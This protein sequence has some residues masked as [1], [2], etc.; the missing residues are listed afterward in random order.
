MVVAANPHQ[1]NH[2][3]YDKKTIRNVSM[4]KVNKCD[5]SL[6][7]AAIRNF[8]VG[9]TDILSNNSCRIN[10]IDRS[11]KTA[12]HHAA[13]VG[14][15][16]IVKKLIDSGSNLYA[17]TKISKSNIFH[18]AALSGKKY[19]LVYLSEYIKET[20]G[21]N[22][23]IRLATSLNNNGKLPAHCA[24]Q[25]G[26][27]EAFMYLIQLDPS[28]I[29]TTTNDG[30]TY[31]HLA[32]E[33]GHF[34]LVQHLYDSKLNFI[35][36]KEPVTTDHYNIF[37]YAFHSGNVQ[38]AKYIVEKYK[39]NKPSYEI[40]IKNQ[41]SKR[42]TPVHAAALSSNI[43][44][45]E[46]V[47]G[48]QNL[49]LNC[50]NM[51]EHRTPLCYAAISGSIQMVEFLL[52]KG[53]ELNAP[54]TVPLLHCAAQ[55]GNIEIIKL[56]LSEKYNLKNQL[57]MTVCVGNYP[58]NIFHAAVFSGTDEMIKYLCESHFSNDEI[59]RLLIC[60]GYPSP[61]EI[62][63]AR[64]NLIAV[65][66]FVNNHYYPSSIISSLNAAAKNRYLDIVEFLLDKFYPIG[67]IYD[68]NELISSPLLNL[69]ATWCEKIDFFKLLIEKRNFD[70]HKPIETKTPFMNALSSGNFPIVEMYINFYPPEDSTF[71]L[72]EVARSGNVKLAKYLIQHIPK[73]LDYLKTFTSTQS[74][75][76]QPI[77][78]AVISKKIKLIRYFVETLGA[79]VNA[80]NEFRLTPLH[81]ASF[82]SFGIC[83]KDQQQII[84]YLIKSGAYI[85]LNAKAQFFPGIHGNGLTPIDVASNAQIKKI[86]EK[87]SPII[88]AERLLIKPGEVSIKYVTLF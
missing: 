14:N 48:I 55:G 61:I 21:E 27:I 23:F 49:Q 57:S 58:T 50:I 78:L 82:T 51:T 73:V 18:C 70:P 43:E 80:F 15:I 36:G 52:K 47:L 79:N 4:F 30:R 16:D 76:L 59:K 35:D 63:C 86:L 42:L 84:E 71:L 56:L 31:H 32:A 53:A 1:N 83:T 29:K 28:Q 64:G 24:A 45:A 8:L 7:T 22:K 72:H 77:H 67:S 37:F 10:E 17:K 40:T 87:Y 54:C 12:L 11:G 69:L 9:V 81:F 39:D 20:K 34:E 5:I 65:E 66:Y 3:K 85:S 38:L 74:G 6:H 13:S 41:S 75:N 68:E 19:L 46:Y 62:A 44:L 26:N 33:R 2:N 25:S 60:D 88:H